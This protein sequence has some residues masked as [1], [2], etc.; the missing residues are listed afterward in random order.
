MANWQLSE[1][2]T[3]SRVTF[4]KIPFSWVFNK[5]GGEGLDSITRRYSGNKPTFLCGNRSIES[6][7]P[8]VISP[9]TKDMSTEI[10]RVYVIYLVL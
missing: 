2:Y 8:K 4:W 9:E 6:S 3:R 7:R 1:C 10:L 5:V